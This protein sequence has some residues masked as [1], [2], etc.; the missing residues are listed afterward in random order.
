MS[1]IV[2]STH[3]VTLKPEELKMS[4]IGNIALEHHQLSEKKVQ[5]KIDSFMTKLEGKNWREKLKEN[6]QNLKASVSN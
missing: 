2:S 5:D 6:Q 4:V 3:I 1:T